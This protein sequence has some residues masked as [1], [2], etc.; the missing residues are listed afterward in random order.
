M[1]NYKWKLAVLLSLTFITLVIFTIPNLIKVF[2]PSAPLAIDIGPWPPESSIKPGPTIAS[3][4]PMVPMNQKEIEK[5]K[6]VS[7]PVGKAK[8]FD[9]TDWY[10]KTKAITSLLADIIT[11]SFPII[12]TFFSFKVWLRQRKEKKLL[13]TA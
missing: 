12:G 8:R 13:K 4:E 10:L 1:F 3:T 11:S 5:L 6:H 2:M 7:E 9:E